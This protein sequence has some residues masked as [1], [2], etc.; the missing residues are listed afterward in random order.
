MRSNSIGP[1]RQAATPDAGHL[2]TAVWMD[3]D[4]CAGGPPDDRGST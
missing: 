3:P 2:G 4:G 1:T